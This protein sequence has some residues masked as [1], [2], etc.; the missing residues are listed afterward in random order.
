MSGGIRSVSVVL[1]NPLDKKDTLEYLIEL[2]DTKLAQDWAQALKQELIKNKL[3]EKNFCF[4]G[5]PHT[6]R[7]LNYLCKELNDAVYRIN[8]FNRTKVWE[9]MGLQP[10]V[11]D[12]F[13]VPDS[14]RFG[15]EYPIGWDES[16]LGLSI[17]HEVM[18][19]L[20]NYF[21]IL[22][23]TVEN[24]SSYYKYADYTTKYAIRQ[25]NNLCHEI[26]NLCLS[27]RKQATAAEWIRPSQI[28]TF[29]HAERYTLTNEHKQ[30]FITNG[31]DRVFG[32]VYM[33]WTQ[34]GK[35]L[36]EVFR[37]ENAPDLTETVCQ[38]ITELKYY[39]GE[40]DVEWGNSVVYGNKDVSWHTEEQNNFREWLS[41]NGRDYKDVSLSCGYL[42]IGQVDLQ[43]SFG[44]TDGETIWKILGNYLDIYSVE[45]DGV[46]NIFDYSWADADYKQIQINRM[47]PGY[48]YSSRR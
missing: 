25:L 35:T 41:K 21:E 36:F 8:V 24:L 42:P 26:E 45:V 2:N 10:F 43:G 32:G 31:Y 4:M 22:Q 23:G 5:F 18:N 34:I 20:H 14:I 40:F 29:L 39:S 6:P 27:Q 48:D 9:T 1:R 3:I 7:N 17:K 13:Y 15:D 16:N 47:K 12:D 19:R 44:N 11:I 28:T 37:D 38:S 30:G 33:H 46:T